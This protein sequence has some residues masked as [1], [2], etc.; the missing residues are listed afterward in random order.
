MER[1]SEWD[2]QWR[3]MAALLRRYRRS[4]G[5]T[6]AEAQQSYEAAPELPLAPAWVRS[7]LAQIQQSPMA[8][9]ASNACHLLGDWVF[10]TPACLPLA[11]DLTEPPSV[12]GI[13]GSQAAVEGT[14]RIQ[15]DVV[16]ARRISATWPPSAWDLD[17]RPT[18]SVVF[19]VSIGCQEWDRSQVYRIRQGMVLWDACIDGYGLD[20]REVA[21]RMDAWCTAPITSQILLGDF[22]RTD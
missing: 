9:A 1:R 19:D 15:S 7:V 5:L 11:A 12:I 16:D 21:S 20:A 8:V 22:S 14:T 13:H 17:A 3:Q 10:C 4:G 2:A 18:D 6:L